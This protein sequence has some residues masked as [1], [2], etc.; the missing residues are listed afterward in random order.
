MFDRANSLRCQTRTPFRLHP[1]PPIRR[2]IQYF[3]SN[4]SIWSWLIEVDQGFS[5][6]I[7]KFSKRIEQKN[8]TLISKNFENTVYSES[9]RR[10]LIVLKVFNLKV[11]CTESDGSELFPNQSS[12]VRRTTG[13]YRTNILREVMRSQFPNSCISIRT[14]GL[15]E[16]LTI[17]FHT[18]IQKL[19]TIV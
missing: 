14:G 13:C 4:N 12:L 5:D 18:L 6:L 1:K 15:R 10:R 2:N 8:A 16:K 19:F 17:V 7:R 11:V 3:L 9:L